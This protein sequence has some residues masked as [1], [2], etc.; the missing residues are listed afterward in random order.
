MAI[1]EYKENGKKQFEV[2]VNG[3]DANGK[4]FQRRRS[5]LESLKEAQ[6]LEFEWKREL[7]KLRDEDVGVRWEEWQQ[8]CLERIRLQFQPTTVE[9]YRG[10]LTKWVEHHWA[11]KNIDAITKADVYDVIFN[12]ELKEKSQFTRRNVYKTVR[13]IFEMAVEEG[14]LNRNPCVGITV[15]V[16]ES[17]S[18]VLTNSEVE[19]FLT[20]AKDGRHR[21]YPIWAMALL[22]GMR[23]GELYAL[24]WSDIDLDAGIISVSKAW[25]SKCGITP[26]KTRRSRV[27]PISEDLRQF[28]IES[29]LA[30]SDRH[31]PVLPRLNEWERGEQAR[32]TREFCEAIGVTSIKFHD[33]RATFITN[34]LARGESLAR[35]M[36]MVGHSELKTTNG[37]LRKA[38]IDVIGGTEKLGYRLP[39]TQP[40][41]LFSIVGGK[42]G[43]V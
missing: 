42:K 29:K 17:D 22:T 4:R 9:T 12:K 13:R 20:E 16:S 6:G 37:Y 21:F 10:H 30:S 35:V 33:L 31:A 18:K 23:S 28:L 1:T 32:V 25:N 2:Y 41:R 19:K 27:V 24:N 14:I 3:R 38:G 7:A 43:G 5:G 8:T 11:K 40:G 15:R 36:S 39:Q 26:T 34:L